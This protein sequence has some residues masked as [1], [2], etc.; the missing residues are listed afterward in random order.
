MDKDDIRQRPQITVGEVIAFLSDLPS[1][2]P[3]FC[4]PS[5]VDLDVPEE[6]QEVIE[7]DEKVKCV[8]IGSCST[9][10]TFGFIDN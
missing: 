1:D 8:S 6:T 9:F 4:A 3:V 2:M 5:V 10:M 7:N